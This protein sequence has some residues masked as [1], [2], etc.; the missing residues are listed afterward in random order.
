MTS[1]VNHRFWIFD[2]DGTL[3][4]AVH[5]FNELRRQLGLPPGRSIL[6]EI[7]RHSGGKRVKLLD[8]LD[9]LELDLTKKA[10]AQQGAHELL[11]ALAARGSCLGIL[12]RNSRRNA[13]ETLRTAG[14]DDYFSA[15][16]VLGRDC[17]APKPS[18]EG[19]EI[20][21]SRWQEHSAQAVMVGDYL[22]DLVA[23]RE[24]GIA[25]VLLGD[26]PTSWTDLADLQV[27]GLEDLLAHL[28]EPE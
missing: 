20:L 3:T 8:R 23:G 1:L 7:D 17:A 12:T 27:A 2:L 26:G 15:E 11:G 28:D 6:E 10:S 25:T 19:I 4:H 24:A 13:V 21:L 22:F 16:C 18:S 14:L 5:D 9:A